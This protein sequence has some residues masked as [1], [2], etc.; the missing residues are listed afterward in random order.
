M[1]NLAQNVTHIPQIVED[2]HHH[3]G[4]YIN[5]AQ[6]EIW[7]KAFFYTDA[8]KIHAAIIGE[9]HVINVDW[10]Q[11]K[12]SEVIACVESCQGTDVQSFGKLVNFQKADL[13]HGNLHYSIHNTIDDIDVMEDEINAILSLVKNRNNH[14]LIGIFQSFHA[15]IVGGREPKTIIIVKQKDRNTITIQ[16]V[17]EYLPQGKVAITHS[18]ITRR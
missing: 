4:T 1:Q 13:I 14:N 6:Y 2:L 12:I 9:S 10:G 17:H 5:P 16:S 15:E 8:L 3:I 7:Q 11:E 18:Q